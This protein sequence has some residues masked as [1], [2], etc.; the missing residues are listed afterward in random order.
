MRRV[1]SGLREHL[2][3]MGRLGLPEHPVQLEQLVILDLAELLELWE[4]PEEME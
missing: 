4:Q 2:A 3:Q 1:R